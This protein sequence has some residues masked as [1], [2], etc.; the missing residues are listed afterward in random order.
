MVNHIIQENCVNQVF[1]RSTKKLAEINTLEPKYENLDE[2]GQISQSAEVPNPTPRLQSNEVP[3]QIQLPMK[4]SQSLS[5]NL[6]KQMLQT[7]E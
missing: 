5:K 1:T 7:L 3:E 4:L 6:L 2:E